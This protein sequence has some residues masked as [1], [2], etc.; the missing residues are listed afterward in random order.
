MKPK[1]ATSSL[2]GSKSKI[3]S[4]KGGRLKVVKSVTVLGKCSAI[5]DGDWSVFPIN[6]GRWTQDEHKIFMQVMKSTVIISCKLQK[7]SAH[8]CLLKL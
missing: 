6:K 5:S 4:K 3:K 7:F 1:S 2:F 8:K